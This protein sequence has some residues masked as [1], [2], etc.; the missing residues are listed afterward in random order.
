MAGWLNDVRAAVDHLA[1][2]SDV[3]GVVAVGFGT[4]G[5]LCVCAA[6]GDE[7]VRAVAA[8][9]APADFADWARSPRSLAEH[10]ERLGLFGDRGI[11]QEFDAWARDLRLDPG[12]G[13]RRGLQPPAAAGH[14]RRR[15]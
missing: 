4:G 9:G 12:G 11:P 14:A 8:L 3:S 15:R 7:R 5:A 6:A 1:E 10:A 13:L 2:R